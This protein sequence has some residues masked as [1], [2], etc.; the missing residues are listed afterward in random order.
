MVMSARQLSWTIAALLHFALV[1]CGAVHVGFR[2][3]AFLLD[4]LGQ[5]SDLSGANNSYSF[6]APA[7]SSQ[8]RVSLA[9]RDVG[10]NEWEDALLH[11]PATV[12]GWRTAGILDGFPDFSDQ[13]RRGLT[14]SWASVMFGRHPLAEEVVVSV[15]VEA[16]PT[17]ADW[18][19]G[20]RS[21]WKPVYKGAFRRKDDGDES[22]NRS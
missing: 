17:M 11:D 15:E 6:F 1:V 4:F 9:M 19:N 3:D 10:G 2:G 8:S 18:R 20:T 5:Y 21:A 14:A 12:F 16:L 13:L 7:V 22:N